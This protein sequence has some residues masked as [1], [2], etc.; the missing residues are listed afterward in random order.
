MRVSDHRCFLVLVGA[1]VLALCNL[2]P[3]TVALQLH[4]Q[5]RVSFRRLKQL[6]TDINGAEAAVPL[7][8]PDRVLRIPAP[9]TSRSASAAAAATE[10]PAA[11]PTAATSAA[12]TATEAAGAAPGL[13]PNCTEEMLSMCSEGGGFVHQHQNLCPVCLF[14]T[15]H[16]G[17]LKSH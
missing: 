7:P 14:V 8:P 1:S 10:A 5:T 15:M 13:T 4:Q 3:S 11:T 2:L 17:K 9:S 12:A 6:P 16:D